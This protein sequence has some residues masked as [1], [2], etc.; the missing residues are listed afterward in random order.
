M[1]VTLPPA[2]SVQVGEVVA[3]S[4]SDVS[5]NLRDG[6]KVVWGGTGDGERKAAVVLPLLTREGTV[7]DV[8]SPNLVTVK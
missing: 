1:L 6:R 5:L 3:R 4:N 7:F 2:L 8:S